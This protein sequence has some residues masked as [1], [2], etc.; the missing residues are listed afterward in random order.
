MQKL[1]C[2]TAYTA[3]DE[4]NVG[5]VNNQPSMT[6][7]HFKQESDV[8][9]IVAQYVKTGVMENVSGE[10]P[11]YGDISAFDTNFDLR[12]AYEAVGAAEEGFMKLPSEIRK[13]LDNDPSLLVSW[14]SDEANKAEAVKYG[15][16]NPPAEEPKQASEPSAPPPAETLE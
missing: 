2:R 8:N 15:L 9:Y 3:R 12:R 13:K 16:F 4:E 10:S 1:K 11:V 14:L 7:Q 6:Q 5:I